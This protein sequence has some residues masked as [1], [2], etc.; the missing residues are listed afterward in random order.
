MD[1]QYDVNPGHNTYKSNGYGYA[2]PFPSVRLSYKINPQN[3]LTAFYNRRVDRPNEVDI[4]IFPKYDDAEIIKVGNPALRPQF[5]NTLELGQKTVW[6]SG[7]FYLAAYH[8]QADG[9]ITRLSTTVAG[10]NLIYAIFQNVGKSYNTGLEMVL[11]QDLCEWLTLDL[12]ANAYRNQ[13]NAFTVENQY[14]ERHVFTADRQRVW[15]GNVKTNTNFHFKNNL[16]AQVSLIYL[17]P[18]IIPQGSIA[19]R[20]SV[21]AGV[22]KMIQSGRGEVT[23]NATDVFNTLI[24]KKEI[25]G[26]NFT[27]QSADYNETQVFRLGYSYKF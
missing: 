10:S 21:N 2:Q 26:N 27:Y 16:D 25:Q 8:K 14:P 22:K 7:D 13:I 20:Y 19:A 24:V 17:A 4:R 5:T 18:D 1:L 3:K 15:S 9:T 23:F 6:S 11:S 12:N